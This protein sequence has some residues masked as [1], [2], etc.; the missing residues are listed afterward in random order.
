MRRIKFFQVEW[1]IVLAIASSITARGQI[2][3]GWTE[4]H[5][6][7][8][9]QLRGTGPSYRANNGVETFS[10]TN[11]FKDGDERA[12]VRV[13][14]DYNTGIHQF[15]GYLK[16]TRLDGT[17]INLKQTFLSGNGAWF[18]CTVDKAMHG[19]LRDHKDK[20][21]LATNV[22]GRTVRLNTI[23]DMNTGKFHVYVDGILK[24]TKT[25]D[26]GVSFND[27]YGAYRSTSGY[28][29]I[30]VEW[31]RVHFW[32]NDH[33]D[34]IS[35]SAVTANEPVV[36]PLETKTVDAT[37]APAPAPDESAD[38]PPAPAVPSP[39]AAAPAPSVPAVS[40]PVAPD[41]GSPDGYVLTEDEK[42]FLAQVI[43]AVKKND[44]EWIAD[45]T[46][47]PLSIVTRDEISVVKT[48]EAYQK[49]LARH[50]NDEVRAKI[51]Q[52]AS[53]PFVRNWQGI[54]V[55]DGVLSFSKHQRSGQVAEFGILSIGNFAFQ[56]HYVPQNR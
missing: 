12:E 55:G 33:L 50:L 47:Y 13:W 10:L 3:T 28:G 42:Q 9:V 18:L 25:S 21:I 15:E 46:A 54:M 49:T 56:P 36:A 27:K 4:V 23:H 7:L 30:S 20:N 19:T 45:H 35:E 44:V 1:L 51:I 41:K 16:V 32:T 31:T 8:Q 52:G 38:T 2:G 22:L 37:P 48:K 26:I 40:A 43:N 5:P 17:S 39:V 29:P 6:R 24:L 14:N 11:S 34:P 53:G